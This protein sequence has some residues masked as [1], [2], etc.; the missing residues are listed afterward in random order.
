MSRAPTAVMISQAS[1]D[2]YGVPQPARGVILGMF[3]ELLR[4]ARHDHQDD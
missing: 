4:L 2:L 1:Q 3:V